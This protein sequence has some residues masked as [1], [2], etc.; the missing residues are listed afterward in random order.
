MYGQSRKQ[1]DQGK[2]K[3]TD[4]KGG[5][6]EQQCGRGKKYWKASKLAMSEG[7]CFPLSANDFSYKDLCGI[8]GCLSK[9]VTA[10]RAH[11]IPFVRGGVPPNNVQLTRS[12]QW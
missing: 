2:S 12:C 8:F 9:T 4:R 10:A 6:W 3:D 1:R 11:A 5:T 7:V